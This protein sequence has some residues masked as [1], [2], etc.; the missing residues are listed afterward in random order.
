VLVRGREGEPDQPFDGK[1]EVEVILVQKRRGKKILIKKWGCQLGVGAYRP[2]K[3]GPKK[4]GMESRTGTGF[5]YLADHG[6]EKTNGLHVERKKL[7]V[8]VWGC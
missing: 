8:A 4:K 3:I 1:G 7:I 5:L 2:L 6:K